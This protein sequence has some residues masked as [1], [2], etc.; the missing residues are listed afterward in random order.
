MSGWRLYAYAQCS[1]C[2]K[3]QQWLASQGLK[4]ELLEITL[5]PPTRLELAAAL[6]QLGRRRL[7]NT[8]G[9]SYR[10]LGA[11]AVKAMDDEAALD[12]LEADGKLIKRPFLVR[13]DGRILTGFSL[14][15]W[16]TFCL[17]A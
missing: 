1:T 3:A 4:P 13:G 9:Q 10:A 5:T 8:S 11:A 15:E 2:R 17:D 14:E 7:F 12:A 6:E 16:Q